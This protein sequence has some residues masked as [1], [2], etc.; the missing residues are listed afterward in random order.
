MV[1]SS[2]A[3]VFHTT[4]CPFFILSG[5]EKEVVWKSTF[6]FNKLWLGRTAYPG[7]Q[8]DSE[9]HT[10]LCLSLICFFKTHVDW[11]LEVY[12]GWIKDGDL[13]YTWCPSCGLEGAVRITGGGWFSWEVYFRA[14]SDFGL[15]FFLVHHHKWAPSRYWSGGPTPFCNLQNCEL[16]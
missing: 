13:M 8:A 9:P 4:G 2:S 14:S 1:P 6:C 12:G 15:F 7:C 5:S 3:P 10:L 16:K 11:C